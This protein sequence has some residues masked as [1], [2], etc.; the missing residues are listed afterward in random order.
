MLCSFCNLADLGSFKRTPGGSNMVDALQARI[1][2]FIRW[3]T[4]G[5]RTLSWVLLL[6]VGGFN[7]VHAEQTGPFAALMVDPA[8]ER[9]SPAAQVSGGFKVQGSDTMHSL[10]RRLVLDFQA[11][12][13]KISIDLKSGGSAKSIAEFVEPPQPGRIVVTEERAK[14]AL[15]VSS[16]RELFDAEIRKFASQ[17]GYE[18]L[19]IPIAVD[20]VALYVHKDNPLKGLTLEQADAIFSTARHRGHK[21]DIATWGDLG[22]GNGWEKAPIQLYGRDRKSGTR[23]FFQEHVL[24]GGEFKSGLK[25]EPG[26]ASVILTLSR[27]QLGIGYS[28]IGLQASNVRIVPLAEIEGMPFITPSAST[29]ADQ[30]YPLRRLLYLYVDKAPGASLS[31]AVQEFLTFVK[32]R[33]GQEAV[34]RAGF[35]PLPMDQVAQ[36]AVAL[37]SSP[38]SGAPQSKQ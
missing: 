11:R 21:Q 1:C 13:P 12:Q 8:L 15:L 25:E 2:P 17:R 27:D 33:E 22:L 4:T 3:A 23:A 10:M 16:S 19:A 37:E 26:A 30:T 5:G 29:V 36:F 20:A 34:V 32:S 7:N 6:V 24:A 14:Q 9:Y 31:P 38:A 35:Y 18:P 28:G